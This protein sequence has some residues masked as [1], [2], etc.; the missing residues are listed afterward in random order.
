L[1]NLDQLD[2]IL[3]NKYNGVQKNPST[4]DPN[5][6]IYILDTGVQLDHVVFDQIL[7]DGK[8]Q[9]LYL[10][11]S[12]KS[13][14]QYHGTHVASVAGGK[15]FGV[16]EKFRIYNYAVLN[17][18]G[19]GTDSMIL[20]GLQSVYNNLIKTKRKGVINMSL[21]YQ[22]IGCPLQSSFNNTF[23]LLNS[24]G[25]I[26]VTAAGNDNFDACDYHFSAYSQC[27]SVGSYT[28]LLSKSD[29]S[30][31][32]ACVD[33]WAPGSDIGGAYFSSKSTKSAIAQLSGTSMA[34]PHI[35]GIV[36]NILMGNDA[37]KTEEVKTILK[38]NSFDVDGCIGD[39][40]SCK[41]VMMPC[42]NS[43]QASRSS[44][45]STNLSLQPCC[46]HCCEKENDNCK[47]IDDNENILKCNWENRQCLP[48]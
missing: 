21:G 26:I 20:N 14:T 43:Q 28:S 40:S 33:I 32:G 12:P 6:D 10:T 17:S 11:G 34:T 19:T 37:L 35:T 1:W 44:D 48:C 24:A 41:G 30:N 46:W 42:L 5:I 31:Y 23:N 22:C 39:V 16:S 3:D 27:I 38:S 18:Q 13:Y 4:I 29:F 2:G 25:A 47:P 36:A 7:Y 8:N 15:Y 9:A 45:V